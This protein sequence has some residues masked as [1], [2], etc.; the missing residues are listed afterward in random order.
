M[1]VLFYIAVNSFGTMLG[2]FCLAR[3]T[4]LAIVGELGF[5][6]LGMEAI[7]GLPILRALYEDYI[8]Y[9]D[10]YADVRRDSPVFAATLDAV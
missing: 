7:T 10:E 9:E 8:L 4:Y 2:T 6:L 3:N 5:S 1:T